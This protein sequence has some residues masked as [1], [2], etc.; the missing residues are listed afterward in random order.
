V[1][2]NVT[3]PGYPRARTQLRTGGA[4]YIA[5]VA[6][7]ALIARV[8][9]VA[10]V[11]RIARVERVVFADAVAFF[12]FLAGAR[13][14]GFLAAILFTSPS[15]HSCSNHPD[16]RGGRILASHSKPGISIGSGRGVQIPQNSASSTT[17]TF[18]V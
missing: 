13:F 17:S 14:A 6:R 12:A 11:A 4:I 3:G 18:I 15:V 10:R 7:V 1:V 16:G 5:R 2:K 9:R 8:A